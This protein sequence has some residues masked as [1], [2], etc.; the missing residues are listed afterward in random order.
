[1]FM[2]KVLPAWAEFVALGSHRGSKRGT[3]AGEGSGVQV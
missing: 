3:E 2:S 1:M